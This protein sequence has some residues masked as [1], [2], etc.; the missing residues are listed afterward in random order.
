MSL[1]SIDVL[2]I[3]CE[4]KCCILF[5]GGSDIV[6]SHLRQDRQEQTISVGE[7]VNIHFYNTYIEI[8][9]KQ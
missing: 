8:M 1:Y 3:N 6:A 9:E 2:I 5:V 7:Y 4:I